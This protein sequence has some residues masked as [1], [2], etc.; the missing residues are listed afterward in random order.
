MHALYQ[1]TESNT[2][3]AR[4]FNGS[5]NVRSILQSSL[6]QQTETDMAKARQLREQ[7]LDEAA[8]LEQLDIEAGFGR[9]LNTIRTE[10]DALEIPYIT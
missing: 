4:P 1:I 9:W 10:L 2:Y 5:Y 8:I 3:A 6:I 7:G